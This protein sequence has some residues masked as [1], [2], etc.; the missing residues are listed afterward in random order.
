MSWFGLKHC[1]IIN[2]WTF[3][4][5]SIPRLVEIRH[6]S[7]ITLEN[8][9]ILYIW[10]I[11]NRRDL[12]LYLP[13]EMKRKLAEIKIP[14]RRLRIIW[15]INILSVRRKNGWLFTRIEPA[16]SICRTDALSVKVQEPDNLRPW[17]VHIWTATHSP[18]STEL[19]YLRDI[20]ACACAHPGVVVDECRGVEQCD[21][22]DMQPWGT[23]NG[24][25]ARNVLLSGSPVLSA[26]EK[27]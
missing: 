16:S 9:Y 19:R 1:C 13:F 7:L 12:F 21:G 17:F 27:L 25:V 23:G 6:I 5:N 26:T 22:E 10:T 8:T 2:H 11:I 3:I 4:E 20:L 24:T 15:N 18:P 14:E